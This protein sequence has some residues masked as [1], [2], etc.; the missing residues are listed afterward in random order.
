MYVQLKVKEILS[1]TMLKMN[2]QLDK[3]Y[4]EYLINNKNINEHI[5]RSI[6]IEKNKI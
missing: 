1:Q 5:I 4:N 6:K 2:E 3:L